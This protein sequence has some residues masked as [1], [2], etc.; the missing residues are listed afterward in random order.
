MKIL[1]LLLATLL[2][3]PVVAQPLFVEYNWTQPDSTVGSTLE[4]GEVVGRMAIPD[5][6]IASYEVMLAA[7]KDT[8][9]Y[10]LVDAPA[11][12]AE[13]GRAV[14]PVAFSQPTSIRV[15]AIDKDGRVSDFG[16]WSDPFT[17]DPGKPVPPGKPSVLRVF[18]GG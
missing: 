3:S 10:G 6:W 17:V 11:T 8:T 15:R 7:G 1:I 13:L 16:E 12:I 2:A 4:S 14:V 5:G 9:L 18:L